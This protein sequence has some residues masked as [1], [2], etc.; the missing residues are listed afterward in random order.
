MSV[1]RRQMGRR[2]YMAIT[3]RERG[4]VPRGMRKAFNAASKRAWADV[5]VYFHEHLRE[6]RFTEEHARAVGYTRRRGE[7]MPR[8]TKAFRRSYT[9]RK[10]QRFG[11]TRPLEFT[12]DTRRAMRT[13]T[14]APTSKGVK[15]RYPGARAFNF[16][17]PQSQVRMNE[18]FRRLTH[19]ETMLLAE[20]YDRQLDLYLNEAG[21]D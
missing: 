14:L 19:A 1:T 11:H 13:A 15:V 9:G 5:G 7:A 8:G 2:G 4:P 10:L 20:V 3:V 21:G 17:H 16:R 12:G 6:A 18:E